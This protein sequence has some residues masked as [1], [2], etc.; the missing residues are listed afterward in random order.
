MLE[1]DPARFEAAWR[2][3]CLGGYLAALEAL[4]VMRDAGTACILF[5]DTTVAFRG[6]AEFAGPAV[7]KFGCA[8]LLKVRRASLVLVVSISPT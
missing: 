2:A 1:L 3:N 7:G 4:P 6:G 8:H 5:T